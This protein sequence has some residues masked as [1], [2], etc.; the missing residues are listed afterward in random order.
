MLH[1]PLKI[2]V[3]GPES[4]GKSVLCQQLATHYGALWCPEYARSYL[5]QNQRDGHYTRADLL[6]IAK[7]Q[8]KAEDLVDSQARQLKD[9]MMLIDT[10]MYVMKIWSEFAFQHCDHWILEQIA[11][12]HYDYYLL[13]DIDLPWAPD[14]LRE[15]PDP[16][17]RQNLFNHYLD[18]LMHQQTPFSI[19]NGQGAA[20]L[21][22]AIGVVDR[23][24]LKAGPDL[25]KG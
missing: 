13:C 24:V 25:Y 1:T 17:M 2:V 12:R 15:Y 21:H 23:E 16:A 14:P 9:A 5:E 10:D 22:K 19:I 18:L 6:A 11:V 4:T 20:R 8:L 3:I 7:G